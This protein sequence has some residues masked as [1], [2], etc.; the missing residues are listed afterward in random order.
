M[1][2]SS[3]IHLLW[4]I[5]KYYWNGG[6]QKKKNPQNIARDVCWHGSPRNKTMRTSIKCGSILRSSS[7][8]GKS[9]FQRNFTEIS[10][11]ILISFTER[12]RLIK[13]KSI[14][15][16][17]WPFPNLTSLLHVTPTSSPVPLYTSC[18][19]I[20][21]ALPP[22]CSITLLLLLLLLLPA[23]TELPRLS[24]TPALP[25]HHHHCGYGPSVCGG[26]CHHLHQSQQ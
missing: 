4:S 1:S 13:T 5:N 25:H 16:F 20:S 8:T 10:K 14:V 9:T 11:K 15:N 2:P 22:W 17:V 24:L 21:K 23:P 6:S 18:H 19:Y 7:R 3:I 26:S 12:L